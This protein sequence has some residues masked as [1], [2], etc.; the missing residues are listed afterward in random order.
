MNGGYIELNFMRTNLKDRNRKMNG[1]HKNTSD[2]R[3]SMKA[4]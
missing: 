2:K 4:R 1:Q 3:A